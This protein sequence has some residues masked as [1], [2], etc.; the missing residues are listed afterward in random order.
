MGQRLERVEGWEQR[1]DAEIAF[2]EGWRFAWHE[3]DCCSFA[4]RCVRAVTLVDVFAPFR[5]RYT[6]G[7]AAARI[8][9]AAG[10]LEG[11][12]DDAIGV[13]RPVNL[14]RRGDVVL[15]EV[16]QRVGAVRRALAVC[17]GTH[18][19]CPGVIGLERIPRS[20]WLISWEVG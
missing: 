9:R 10:G 14:A 4:A 19:L 11:L 1:L 15:V 5:D 20:Q 7:R 18:A 17:A 13:R 8:L 3:H 12:A 16:Q 6:N 2:F